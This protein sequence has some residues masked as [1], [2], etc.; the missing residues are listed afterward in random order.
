MNKYAIGVLLSLLI[1]GMGLSIANIAI[2]RISNLEKR[3]TNEMYS[4]ACSMMIPGAECSNYTDAK[5]LLDNIC[6]TSCEPGVCIIEN[7]DLNAYS[8]YD[9]Q[10]CKL[11]KNTM[12]VVSGNTLRVSMYISTGLLMLSSITVLI[13]LGFIIYNAIHKNNNDRK[14]IGMTEFRPCYDPL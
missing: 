13:V 5:R 2:N 1:A 10:L 6:N 9:R 12:D 7:T 4:A 14:F 8:H 11:S 3:I